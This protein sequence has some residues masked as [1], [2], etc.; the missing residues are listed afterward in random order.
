MSTARWSKVNGRNLIG[1]DLPM[2]EIDRVAVTKAPSLY[3]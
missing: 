3:S 1:E 2:T